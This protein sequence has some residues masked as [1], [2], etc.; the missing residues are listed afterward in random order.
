MEQEV[1]VVALTNTPRLLTGWGYFAGSAF[2]QAL[3]LFSIPRLLLL[4]RKSKLL[5]H[6][7]N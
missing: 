5:Y 3:S 4:K 6:C 2:I 1:E 7:K